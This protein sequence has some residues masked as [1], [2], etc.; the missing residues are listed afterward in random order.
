VSTDF[1][2][3]RHAPLVPKLMQ[4]LGVALDPA[5]LERLTRYVEL[6]VSWNKKLDLT[7]ARGPEAQLEVLLADAVMLADEKITPR[8]SRVLDVGS[9]AGAP[10][11]ALLLAREDLDV[12]LVEPLQKRVAFLRTV[13]GTLDCVAR[14]RVLRAKLEP[15][16]PQLV[17]AE[18]PFDVALSR[19]TFAPEIWTPL[20]ARLAMRTLT[21]LAAQATPPAPEGCEL[22]AEHA[23]RLPWSSAP[24]R[25]AVYTRTSR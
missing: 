2:R 13:L 5:T 8:G 21:L 22:S 23:Y 19:A 24:R 11:L 1:D 20:G 16:S 18:L 3:A 14:A 10:G 9:G 7:A 12:T 17:E 4:T 25:L 15:E 6:V